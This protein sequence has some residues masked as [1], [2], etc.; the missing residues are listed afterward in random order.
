MAG[1]CVLVYSNISIV[2]KKPREGVVSGC[3]HNIAQGEGSSRTCSI[4]AV[5]KHTHNCATVA[6]AC[7]C[8]V[9]FI[10]THTTKKLVLN[11]VL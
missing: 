1:E 7:T 3:G 4:A 2:G 11:V 8:S 9:Q 5:V 10:Y 6:H